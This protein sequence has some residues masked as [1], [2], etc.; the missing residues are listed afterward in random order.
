[1]VIAGVPGEA[2]L[3]VRYFQKWDLKD[4]QNSNLENKATSRANL[5][6]AISERFSE[7][8]KKIR[9]N[10]RLTTVTQEKHNFWDV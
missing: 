1:M 10:M 6:V 2:R 9:R 8:G 5:G 4:D 3:K 7:M